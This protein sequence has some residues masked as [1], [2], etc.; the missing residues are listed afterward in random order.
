MP[1]SA[2]AVMMGCKMRAVQDADETQKRDRPITKQ[3]A[4]AD[5][6]VIIIQ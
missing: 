6:G 4:I 2:H 5:D 1:Y 3:L